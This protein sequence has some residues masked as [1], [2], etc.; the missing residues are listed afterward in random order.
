M[1]IKSKTFWTDQHILNNRAMNTPTKATRWHVEVAHEG[2][3]AGRV[4]ENEWS[5]IRWETVSEYNR[6]VCVRMQAID[7]P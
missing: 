3:H 4:R 6:G 5:M 7:G 2:W 1:W